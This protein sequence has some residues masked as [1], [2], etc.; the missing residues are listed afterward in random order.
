MTTLQFADTHN[1]VAFLAKPAKSEG[2]EQVVDFMNASSIRYALTV[3]PTI[4]TSCIEQFWSTVKAKTVNEEQ[5][6]V[7]NLDSA[8]KFLMYPR[9]VQVF[10]VNQLE[11]MINHNKIYIAP[12]HIKKVFANMKRQ[13]KD[14]SGRVTPLFSTMMV[15]AQQEQGEADE[16]VYKERDDSL[17]RATTTATGLDAKQDKGGGPMRQD[18]IGDTI[19]QTRIE[20]SE[21][22]GLGEEDASKQ[23]RIDDIDANEYIYLVNVHI[24]EDMFGVNNLE[25]DEV[26][27]E[28]E[29]DHEVVVETEVA[30]KDVNLS[31]DEV[32]LAQALAALKSAKPKADK[33]MLQEPEQGTIT[34]ITAATTVT[35]ASTRPKDKGLVIHKEE[36]ATT[37]T[38]SSQQPSQVKVQDK[39]K[40]IMVEEPLKMKKKIKLQAQE[41]DELTNE[42]KATLFV[43]FLEQR[44]K[45][46]AAKR[47][48]EKRNIPPTRAQQRSIMCTYL[49]NMEGWK[50]KS[51]KSKSFIAQ[52]SSSKR[53]GESLEQESSKKQKLEED[54]ESEEL[55][56]CLEIIPDDGDDVTIDA[57][58]LSNKS[59]IIMLKNSNRENLEV[60]WS[61]VKARF[62]K[63][64]PVNYTDNFLL[65]NLKTMFEHH[66]EDSSILYD[67]LVEKMYPLTNNT[68][69]QM[70]ND[71]KLQ[72]DYEC[73]MAFELLRLVKK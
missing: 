58:P 47:A 26:I 6:M 11:G 43:Q 51:L 1:L 55:K 38:V 54:K 64:E 10:L 49:K 52:E 63:T 48:E 46:F 27:V 36:Q 8:G 28:T 60:L 72:V 34:T 50:P 17:E 41:Q 7:K 16:A 21:D 56:Q 70:F 53:A 2:F 68:L 37:P 45:H 24:D 31:V 57:T 62:K 4:Y 73:E 67:L 23:G 22:E 30:S 32:T 25:G 39:G 15:Q 13:G 42:E 33:V 65:L 69:H 5:Y 19:A 61:I 12:S 20:S 14:F 29:V 9:F 44:R 40:G 71:V 3:N 18:T 66:V 35:A 59:P